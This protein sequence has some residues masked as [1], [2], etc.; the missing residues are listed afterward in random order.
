MSRPIAAMALCGMVAA[1]V[2]G[3]STAPEEVVDPGVRSDLIRIVVARD[4]SGAV[5]PAPAY[6]EANRRCRETFDSAIYFM[7]ENVGSNERM[8]YFRC[9]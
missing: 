3:C 2:T 1:V 8:L 5:D 7:G 6:E 9:Q 4:E